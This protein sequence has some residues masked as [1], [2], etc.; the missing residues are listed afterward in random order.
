[1]SASEIPLAPVQQ[2]RS[3]RSDV[4]DA[5]RTA[6]ILGDLVEGELYSAPALAAPLG[7]SAHRCVRR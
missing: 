6:I 3:L 1:M 4:T 5:L 7:V 2:F